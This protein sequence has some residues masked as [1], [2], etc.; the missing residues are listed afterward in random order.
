MSVFFIQ[1]TRRAV[2]RKRKIIPLRASR[3]RLYI[4]PRSHACGVSAISTRTDTE[5]CAVAIEAAPCGSSSAK[6][7]SS[8]AIRPVSHGILLAMAYLGVDVGGTFTDA[9]LLDDDAVATAKVLTAERQ[10]GSVVAAAHVVASHEIAPEF[11]EY[12]R[13]STT[14]ADAYLGPVAG[15]YLRALAQASAAAGLPE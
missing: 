12:E 11:R 10:E 8:V 15:R 3:R 7:A 2:D 9:V 5:P 14:V 1:N 6:A 13:A 4:R